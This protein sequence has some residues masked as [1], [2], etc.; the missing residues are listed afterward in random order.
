M[1][2]GSLVKMITD[3]NDSD[4][5]ILGKYNLKRF[6]TTGDNIYTISDFFKRPPNWVQGNNIKDCVSLEEFPEITAQ[7]FYFDAELFREIQSPD[8]VNVAE[9]ISDS[10]Y[11]KA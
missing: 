7:K 2:N 3:I 6:P 11:A 9:V 4:K 10:I 8:E 1:Q 5:G